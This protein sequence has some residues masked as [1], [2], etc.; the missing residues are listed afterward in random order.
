MQ[1]LPFVFFRR[2]SKRKRLH[3]W[4]GRYQGGVVGG[5]NTSAVSSVVEDFL[6]ADAAAKKIGANFSLAT[7]GWTLGPAEDRAYFDK[8]L[9]PGWTLTSIDETLGD[10]PVESAYSNVTAH[11][12]WIIPWAEDDPHLGT[13]QLW[14]NRTLQHMEQAQGYGVDG[15]L[16][17]TWR[18]EAVSPT[19]WAL[20]QRGWNA[21]LTASTAWTRWAAGEFGLTAPGDAEQVGAALAAFEGAERL[22]STSGCPGL[23]AGCAAPASAAEFRGKVEA[24]LAL[25]PLVGSDPAYVE[26]WNTWSSL[27]RYV[28]AAADAGCVAVNYS[29]AAA[30]VR[31]MPSASDRRTAAE[32]TLLPLMIRLVGGAQNTTTLL[33]EAATGPGELGMLATLHDAILL[34]TCSG[35]N[36]DTSFHLNWLNAS[37]RA[38]L[39]GW[40][41][42]SLPAEATPT[43]SYVG[44]PRIVMGAARSSVDR[45]EALPLTARLLTPKKAHGTVEIRYKALGSSQA[46]TVVQMAASDR[47]HVYRGTVP[48]QADDFEFIIQ[49]KTINLAWPPG[50][51]RGDGRAQTVV[52]I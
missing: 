32:A 6:A 19:L 31:G 27:F 16:A 9:P 15:A 3:R 12:S 34:G 39:A 5:I 8:V 24:F 40:L 29:T 38:E 21:S 1:P 35:C 41:N 17:I 48:P 43:T 49:A 52:V 47:G 2:S 23:V 7:S 33:L 45:G 10:S 11:N 14:V 28:V 44:R 42:A 51:E 18:M 36:A 50:S 37:A 26:R 30:A 22:L 13:T 46:W 20:A 4:N 25:A